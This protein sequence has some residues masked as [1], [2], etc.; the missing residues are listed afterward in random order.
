LARV[1]LGQY[2]SPVRRIGAALLGLVCLACLPAAAAAAASPTIQYLSPQPLRNHE[3]TLHFTVDPEGLATVYEVEYGLKAGEYFPNHYLWTRE[4]PA[5][6]EPVAGETKVPAYFEGKLKAG[7]EYHWRVV[8]E[9]SA[10]RTEGPDQVFTTTDGA[11]PTTFT[12]AATEQTLS[13]AV[14]HGTID[15]EGAPVQGCWFQV[16]NESSI[17]NKGWSAWDT[18]ENELFG[19]L[20]PCVE[21]PEE[22][23]SG[24]SQVPVHATITGLKA[25]PYEVRLEG[26]NEYEEQRYSEPA[27]VGP[28]RVKTLG[29]YPV[30]ASEA[31]VHGF[32]YKQYRG[33]AAYWVEYGIGALG[34][35]TDT[36]WLSAMGREYDLAVTLPCLKPD[37]DYNY[38]FAALNSAGTVYGP[39][40][41][42]HSAVGEPAGCSPATSQAATTSAQP[43]SSK[44]ARRKHR[45]KRKHKK[46]RKHHG[47]GPRRG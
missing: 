3:A 26:S 40:G 36:H 6:E 20:V 37:S 16:L 45:H 22:I 13:S 30:G 41:G 44:T 19:T 35:K 38:R 33:E 2:P 31:T 18:Y 14:L 15:P 29:A 43:T 8:A 7:T 32:V 17:Q 5:G 42:F 23:G 39:E 47:S 34:E 12:L 28:V 24:S 25:E 1:P 21:T 46:H 4:L 11:P 27:L 9:N 10:G